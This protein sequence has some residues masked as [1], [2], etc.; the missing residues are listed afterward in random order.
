MQSGIEKRICYNTASA[1]FGPPGAEFLR[2]GD[3][4]LQRKTLG[5]G[6]LIYAFARVSMPEL[7]VEAGTGGSSFCALEAIRHNEFGHLYTVDPF[8]GCQPCTDKLPPEKCKFHEDGTPYAI[9]H[10]EILEQMEQMY[11]GLFTFEYGR[12]EDVSAKWDR[13]ID[14]VVVDAWHGELE[15][16]IL[17]DNW[18][19]WLKPGGY[20]LFHD[21]I[22]C[23]EAVGKVISEKCGPDSEFTALIEPNNLGMA[24]VQRKFSLDM[25]RF[26]FSAR[27]THDT[28]PQFQTTP[29]QLHGARDFGICGKWDGKLAPANERLAD[30]QAS[31]WKAAEALIDSGEEQTV[32]NMERYLR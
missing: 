5:V 11:P 32:E 24:I 7:I 15:T 16:R 3:G 21:P 12:A 25:P 30:E 13:P 20:M 9:E 29:V 8:P 1:M 23:I 4:W 14:M 6:W 22:A 27:L 19:P 31:A 10:I 26:W 28:N 17:W 18:A 2:T